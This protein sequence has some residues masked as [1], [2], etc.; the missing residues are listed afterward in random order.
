MD[1]LKFLLKYKIDKTH[2]QTIQFNEKIGFAKLFTD[3]FCFYQKGFKVIYFNIQFI[4]L[5]FMTKFSQP[6][7]YIGIG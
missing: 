3:L 5:F 7:S 4:N 2:K 6:L 1:V